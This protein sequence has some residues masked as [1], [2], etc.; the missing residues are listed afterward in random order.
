MH[1]SP[2]YIEDAVKAA[3]REDLGHGFDATSDLLIPASKRARGILR[4]R[5]NGYLAGLIVALSTFSM[6][7]GDF[8]MSVHI[9]DGERLK[10]GAAIAEIEGPARA[11]LT[12]ER[13]ALNFLNHMS[14]VASLTAAYVKEVKGTGAEIC[15]TRKTLP[16]LR[17]FQKYAV[18]VGGGANHRFGLDDA[19]L[20]KDNHIAVAGGIGQALDQA[21]MLAGHTKK[22][23][24][25]VDTLKQL[26][27]VLA[28]GG[29]DI[30]MLDNFTT[31]DLKRAVKMGGGH[32]PLEASGGVTLESVK[33]IAQTGVDYISVGAL[34]HSVPQLD[35]G[36]DIKL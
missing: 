15:D 36:L 28:H 12:G 22:I 26:E 29:A 19:L 9:Q 10:P 11:M 14:G 33:A 17:L 3:L 20:I 13:V 8:E 16:G 7:H 25:E 34:T 21:R 18:Y 4:T 2:L 31:P 35:I 23:E 24:I 1:L 27:E 6:L 5:E 30:I 32:V